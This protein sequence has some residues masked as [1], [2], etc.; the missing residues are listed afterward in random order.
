MKPDFEELFFQFL[1]EIQERANELMTKIEEKSVPEPAKVTTTLFD[2]VNGPRKGTIWID[3]DNGPHAERYTVDSV[4]LECGHVH[5]E[6]GGFDNLPSF[7]EMVEEGRYILVGLSPHTPPA[8]YD[9]T[10]K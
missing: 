2:N 7:L 9:K 8:F 3:F 10:Y 4:D 1:D 6:D 5:Y